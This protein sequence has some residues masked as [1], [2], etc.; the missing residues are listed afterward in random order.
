MATLT[1]LAGSSI[2]RGMLSWRSGTA[3][4]WMVTRRGRTNSPRMTLRAG[5][6]LVQV[7][8]R[9]SSGFV[10][11]PRHRGRGRRSDRQDARMTRGRSLFRTSGY[12][13]GS[14]SNAPTRGLAEPPSRTRH[15]VRTCCQK[16][17]PKVGAIPKKADGVPDAAPLP[18]GPATKKSQVN[19]RIRRTLEDRVGASQ[20]V[21]SGSSSE[22][23]MSWRSRSTPRSR[24]RARRNGRFP[25]I[26]QRRH[27]CRRVRDAVCRPT[28]ERSV[29]AELLSL[30]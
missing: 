18:R 7:E 12:G 8:T 14:A 22:P 23:Q 27:P 5:N 10:D 26:R 25:K 11:A 24:P 29:R 17:H 9:L 30:Y 15:A 21:M 16:R 19:S 3:C 2:R 20:Q 4:G 28:A 1:A 13:S 6:A